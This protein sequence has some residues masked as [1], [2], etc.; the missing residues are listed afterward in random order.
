MSSP[1]LEIDLDR[2]HLNGTTLVRRLAR[3]GIAI[4]AVSKA[5]L[6]RRE[7]VRTWLEAG[8]TSIGDSRIET[9]EDM[10]RGGVSA[11]MLLIRTPMLSQVERV[12]A[13]AASSCNSEPLVIQALG[14]AAA[15]QQRCHGVL[16]MVEL[17][18]RREGLLPGDL[19]AVARLTLS[20]PSLRLVGI[21]TNLG[22]QHGVAPDQTN[23]AELSSL[24]GTLEASLRIRLELVSGGNSANLPWL[25]EGGAPGR[26]NH[27]RLGEALL[28]GR[29]PLTRTA[30]AGLC[31]DAFSLVGELI[32]VKRKP[33]RPLGERG[34]TSFLATAPA[35]VPDR[36][37]RQRG[38]VALGVQDV[39]PAD[40]ASPPGVAIVG[41]SSDHLVV[42]A[43][44]P[45]QVG[46]EL[47]FRPGY[48]ALLRAMTSPFVTKRFH[49]DAPGRA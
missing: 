25:A 9:L 42:E 31:S 44:R 13:H 11:D 15:D 39:D 29:D 10:A 5:C 4:T 19:E 33:S 38:L 30:I 37:Q 32:E 40:L 2:L 43:E 7:I 36:G 28:L 27:L 6:G 8:I 35:S 14:A 17:G 16:L 18:D 22:C 46:E 3:Q 20:L 12:V 23:M 21:G 49:Q 41:A 45:L 47:R 48:S 26:I 24:A 1:R 34:L